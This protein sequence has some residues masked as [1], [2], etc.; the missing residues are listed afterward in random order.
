MYSKRFSNWCVCCVL[1]LSLLAVSCQKDE[2]DAAIDQK[3]SAVKADSALSVSAPGNY[4]ATSG[5]LTIKVE[6]STYTF[7]AGEDSVAFVNMNVGD[8]RYFGITAIN[9]AHTMSFGVSSKGIANA[10][11]SGAVEGSQLLLSPDAIH[12][13]Q[14]TLTRFTEPGDAGKI[15]LIQYRRDTVLAQ[16]TFFTFLAKD[17]KED[18]PFYRV[19]GSFNLQMKK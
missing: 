7:D 19:E 1:F 3:L 16:G 11:L 14:Y 5:T 8:S 17:D 2:N 4:L 12:S 15:S 9:K 6:D 10:D 18:S 13:K